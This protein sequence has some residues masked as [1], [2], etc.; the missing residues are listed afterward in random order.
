MGLVS[1][2]LKDALKVNS[3]RLL[4]LLVSSI[5]FTIIVNSMAPINLPFL[6]PDGKRP[7]LVEGSWQ[8]KIIFIDIESVADMGQIILIDLRDSEDFDRIHAQGAINL[9]Y[10]YFDE[11]VSD[12]IE[13]VDEDQQILLFCEGMLCGISARAAKELQDLGYENISIIKQGF[14]GWKK[15]NLPIEENSGKME[16][17]DAAN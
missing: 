17:N 13:K 8:E 16:E 9:P 12:F 2:S 10:F 11:A 6:L 5:L 15:L 3:V 14:D 1:M 7:G 4:I